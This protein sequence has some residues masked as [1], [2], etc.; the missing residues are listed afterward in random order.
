MTPFNSRILRSGGKQ[1][2]ALFAETCAP[3]LLV[4]TGQTSPLG[5]AFAVV[6]WL[7][8]H[9][10]RFV[11]ADTPT[12]VYDQSYAAIIDYAQRELF[13]R[14]GLPLPQ[15]IAVQIELYEAPAGH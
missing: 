11:P 4:P 6:R 12:A 7:Q 3:S 14:L 9:A 15:H 5:Q 1:L 2:A 13:F 8:E 10:P